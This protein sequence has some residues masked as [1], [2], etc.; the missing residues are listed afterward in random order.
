MIELS[1]AGNVQEDAASDRPPS[2]SAFFDT[3]DVGDL[4]FEEDSG[5][6]G[7]EGFDGDWSHEGSTLSSDEV[8]SGDEWGSPTG[9]ERRRDTSS[10]VT[11]RGK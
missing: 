9:D 6:E 3:E 11:A 1:G 10:P 8:D 7:S 5:D 2:P 4:S